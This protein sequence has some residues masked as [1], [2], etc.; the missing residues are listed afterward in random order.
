MPARPPRHAH[1]PWRN[2]PAG[3]PGAERLYTIPITCRLDGQAHDVADESLAAGKRTGEY[4]AL[5]GYVV[6][7][8]PL[9]APVGRRCARCAAV[10]TSTTASVGRPRHRLHR[11]L[12]QLL[13][14]HRSQAAVGAVTRR[15]P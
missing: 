5:C 10:S 11:R 12:L 3:V 4:A 15:R 9:V 6:S 7:A 8:A 2:V 14:P 1:D 13:R